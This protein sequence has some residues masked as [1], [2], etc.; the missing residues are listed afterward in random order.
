MILFVDDELRQMDSYVQ[1]LK[2]S[3]FELSQVNNVDEA[4]Q[5]FNEKYKEI[6]L[7]ILDIMMAPGAAF[8]SE[9]TKDGLRTGESFYRE[10][11]KVSRDLPIILF[12]NVSDEQ[13]E[14]R[15]SKEENCWFFRKEEFF[16]YELASKVRKILNFKN[17]RGRQ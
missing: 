14:A 1:E 4:L 12:T 16:P 11:R 3:G 17:N 5:Y 15:F 7:V 2:L 10:I 9:E 8:S 13:V 6:S